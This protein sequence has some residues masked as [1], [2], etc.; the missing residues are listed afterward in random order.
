MILT[1]LIVATGLLTGGS[2]FVP[3]SAGVIFTAPLALGMMTG[4][5][6]A[7]TVAGVVNVRITQSMA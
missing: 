2:P 6:S 3:T 4:A 7:A 1:H 5:S